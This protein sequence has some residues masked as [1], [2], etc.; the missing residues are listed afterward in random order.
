[1]LVEYWAHIYHEKPDYQE[2]V[3]HDFNKEE[4]LRRMAAGEQWDDV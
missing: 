4:I 2:D 3:D 1:M